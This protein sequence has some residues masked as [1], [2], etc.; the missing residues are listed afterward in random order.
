MQPT[1]PPKRRSSDERVQDLSRVQT[2][3]T[4]PYWPLPGPQDLYRPLTSLFHAL[5]F[6]VG[7]G[8]PMVFRVVSYS[9][10]AL[11]SVAVFF[12]ARQLTSSRPSLVAALVF[13]AHPVHVEAVALAVGQAELM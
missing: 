4:A 9:L 7:D 8:S 1:T 12:L 6:I 3:L 2:I 5:Q 13:A 10:Y 11:A